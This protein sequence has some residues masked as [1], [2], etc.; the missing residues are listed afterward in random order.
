MITKSYHL[1]QKY[2]NLLTIK[3]TLVEQDSHSEE[4]K[5]IKINN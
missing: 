4:E 3:L 1:F 5:Q 2:I